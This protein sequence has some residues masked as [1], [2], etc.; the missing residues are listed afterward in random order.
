MPLRSG[1]T[2]IDVV[3]FE[4]VGVLDAGMGR[5][6]DLDRHQRRHAVEHRLER[7]TLTQKRAVR[8]RRADAHAR[9]VIRP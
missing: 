6:A 5:R 1:P 8:L 3:Y 4:P 7:K 9:H 2:T